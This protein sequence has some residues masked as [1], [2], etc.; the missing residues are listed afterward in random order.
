MAIT[1]YAEFVRAHN[2][3]SV[4]PPGVAERE[5][6]IAFLGHAASDIGLPPITVPSSAT[7]T[8]QAFFSAIEQAKANVAARAAKSAAAPSGGGTVTPQPAPS[9]GTVTPQ[10]TP[11]GGGGT[12]TPQPAPSGGGTA[13][14]PGTTQG[15]YAPAANGGFVNDGANPHWQ[16]VPNPSAATAP[17]SSVGFWTILGIGLSLIH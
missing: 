2:A 9:G 17:K 5:R 15:D 1:S 16:A 12:V 8:A 13:T 3:S 6:L 10:P 14:L 7:A 11:S 4:P